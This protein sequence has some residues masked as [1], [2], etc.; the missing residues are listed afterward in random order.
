MG[1]IGTNGAE[2]RGSTCVFPDEGKKFKRKADEGQGVS[3][4]GGEKLIHGEETQLLQTY[5][6]RRQVTVAKWV[7]LR[8]IFDV[9]ARETV[10]EGG[11]EIQVP[12]WRQA[13]AEKQLKV[14]VEDI[15]M[16]ARLRL[17]WEF[18]KRGESKRG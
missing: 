8:P 3:E 17:R 13:A 16:S 1:A 15:L 4:G 14:V 5:L 10:H 6:E 9:Y 12:W 11:G 2:V 7:A 18:V